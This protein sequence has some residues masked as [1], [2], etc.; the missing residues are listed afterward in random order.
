MPGTQYK[1]GWKERT[2]V[3]KVYFVEIHLDYGWFYRNSILASLL[4]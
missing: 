3:Q 2:I 4:K 1:K